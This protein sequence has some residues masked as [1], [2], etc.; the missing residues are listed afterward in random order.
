MGKV[1]K[2]E[3]YKFS[4][5]EKWINENSASLIAQYGLQN[6]EI[7]IIV[8]PAKDVTEGDDTDDENEINRDKADTHFPG[9]AGHS[10][11][12]ITLYEEHIED[13]EDLIETFLHELEHILLRPYWVY[14]ESVEVALVKDNPVLENLF[15]ICEEQARAN[16]G[17]MRTNLIKSYSAAI[18][19][20]LEGVN[21]EN[22]PAKR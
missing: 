21:L 6:W 19:E 22:G 16:I 20:G 9:H 12:E 2:L 13:E 5:V 15:G 11:A 18:V 7:K 8:E 3:E 1:L 17:A 10:V 4:W 14:K